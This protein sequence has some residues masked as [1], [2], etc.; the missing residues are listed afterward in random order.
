M[1]CYSW[2]RAPTPPGSGGLDLKPGT[3][4]GGLSWGL[5][6]SS[7]CRAA[8]GKEAGRPPPWPCERR[9]C[10]RPSPR[11]RDKALGRFLTRIENHPSPATSVL[12]ASP[13]PPTRSSQPPPSR[14]PNW[15]TIPSRLPSRAVRTIL[16]L[17]PTTAAHC[18]GEVFSCP[19]CVSGRVHS[20]PPLC[21]HTALLYSFA[22]V[23]PGG[24]RP[25][26]CTWHRLSLR[27]G[28]R[29]RAP[30]PAHTPSALIT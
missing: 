9:G 27:A 21:K 11:T 13:C 24:G 14:L 1:V 8:L 4:A 2:S 25:L 17:A 29:P 23:V 26:S 20:P 30:G 28:R 3:A 6:A 19:G 5:R 12:S 16:C 22:L 7:P 10:A 15:Q 18:P